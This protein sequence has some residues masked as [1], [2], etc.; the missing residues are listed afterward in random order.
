MSEEGCR[1]GWVKIQGVGADGLGEKEVA[2]G[3]SEGEGEGEDEDVHK[4]TDKSSL[5]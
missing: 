3:W 4:D 2:G 5:V 1:S